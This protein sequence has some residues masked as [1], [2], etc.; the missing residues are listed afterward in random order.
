MRVSVDACG[1]DR[2]L[3]EL[4]EAD[5]EN[6]PG[7]LVLAPGHRGDRRR[8]EDVDRD[9]LHGDVADRQG[10]DL[11]VADLVA[12]LVDRRPRADRHLDLGGELIV[13][14][15]IGR[16]GVDHRHHLDAADLDLDQRQARVW[17]DRAGP[18]RS[19]RRLR[20]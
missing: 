4:E 7:H 15:H 2:D 16:A 5:P 8:R 1:I 18:G 12:L 14:D 6:G 10:I 9:V 19:S 17:P 3:E 11:A 13:E 20:G